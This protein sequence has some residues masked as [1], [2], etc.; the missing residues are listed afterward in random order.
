MKLHSILGAV[1]VGAVV[2]SPALAPSA[3]AQDTAVVFAALDTNHDGKISKTE[4]QK[5]PMV[6]QMFHQADKNH[7]GFLSR[8]E[9]DAAFGGGTGKH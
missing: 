7:D 2:I 5:N 8:E 9:F 3:L 6:A 1:L 4:A